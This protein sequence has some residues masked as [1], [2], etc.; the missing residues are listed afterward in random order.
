MQSFLK[1][2]LFIGVLT[3]GLHADATQQIVKKAQTDIPVFKAGTDSLGVEYVVG[4]R[5]YIRADKNRKR[6]KIPKASG[7]KLLCFV[8]LQ[9]RFLACYESHLLLVSTKG[10]VKT[11]RFELKKM[12][13]NPAKSKY[14]YLIRGNTLLLGNL[15]HILAVHLN[16]HSAKL[17]KRITDP[18]F[19]YVKASRDQF[20]FA[21]DFHVFSYSL[22]N[23][24]QT[25]IAKS[26]CTIKVLELWKDNPVLVCD[27]QVIFTDSSGKVLHKTKL[28]GASRIKAAIFKEK[29]HAYLT[30]EN[31][32][33]VFDLEQKK[34]EKFPLSSLPFHSMSWLGD[35]LAVWSDDFFDL[36]ESD[37]FVISLK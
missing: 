28:S 6:Y 31:Y 17:V 24:K 23:K 33:F 5:Y 12:S 27:N 22:S 15:E 13:I 36:I 34:K 29:K 25:K 8:P 1:F 19:K 32:L 26:P 37:S 14:E 2:C 30:S 3:T 11:V 7:E 18:D 21:S 9:N 20:W 16:R 35:H 4:D 10:S